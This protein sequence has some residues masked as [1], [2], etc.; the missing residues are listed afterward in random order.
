M[1]WAALLVFTSVVSAQ[2]PH[3]IEIYGSLGRAFVGD[4]EGSLG[5]GWSV[6]GALGWRP[7]PRLGI[8]LNVDR[9]HHLRDLSFAIPEGNGTFVTGD[10]LFHFR[11]GRVQ[12]YILGG[13]GFVRYTRVA[14][15]APLPIVNATGP[16]LNA[17]FGVKGYLTS[18]IVLRPEWRL[19]Y[20]SDVGNAIEPPLFYQRISVGIG[21]TW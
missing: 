11:S 9:F 15:F 8:E 13:G 1:K 12:P 4:D 18:R 10:A 2:S 21:Y 17:A 5:S 16:A 7:T 14:G 3:K 20:V 6:A 19:G